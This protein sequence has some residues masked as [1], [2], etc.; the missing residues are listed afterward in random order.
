MAITDKTPEQIVQE[1]GLTQISGSE[2]L[3][4]IVQTVLEKNTDVVEEYKSGKTKVF[5]FLMGQVMKESRGKA[6]PRL[7]KDILEKFL[8]N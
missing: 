8:A 1:R 4:K 6:N 2:E 7:A 5:A 3:E